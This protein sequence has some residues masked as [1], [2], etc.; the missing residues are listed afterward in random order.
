[1][2]IWTDPV[3]GRPAGADELP[4]SQEENGQ[5]EL[6]VASDTAEPARQTQVSKAPGFVPCYNEYGWPIPSSL[7]ADP[8]ESR[9]RIL[10]PW[11]DELLLEKAR[12]ISGRFPYAEAEYRDL[13]ES[14]PTSEREIP[15]FEKVF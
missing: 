2:T 14:E 7:S 13:R 15:H 5:V 4:P 1:M 11:F 10:L 9:T 12:V 6:P 8:E 3:D